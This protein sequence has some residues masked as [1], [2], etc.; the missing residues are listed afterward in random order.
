MLN[1][2]EIYRTAL[3][4]VNFKL[5]TDENLFYPPELDA[6]LDST[7][8]GLGALKIQPLRVDLPN[9]A[10]ASAVGSAPAVTDER[11]RSLAVELK[12][13]ERR[14]KSE[15]DH[16]M[17][18][19]TN[20]AEDAPMSD[21]SLLASDA[22]ADAQVPDEFSNLISEKQLFSDQVFF[23]NR[24]AR[25]DYLEFVIRAMGGEVVA[26]EPG[27]TTRREDPRITYEVVDRPSLERTFLGR[28]YVQPQY[29]FDCVNKNKLLPTTK[30][31]PGCALPPHL[32][33]FIDE[34]P[35][36]YVPRDAQADDVAG[37]VGSE[38][39]SQSSEFEEASASFETELQAEMAGVRAAAFAHSESRSLNK[40]KAQ[41]GDAL[42]QPQEE[43]ALGRV[44]MNAKQRRLAKKQDREQ[45]Q[46]REEAAR[47]EAKRAALARTKKRKIGS[48]D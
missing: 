44:L 41:R 6:A 20:G 16:D 4:F 24:E 48:K 26:E 5:Y 12:S 19:S 7:G 3:G 15:D 43:A 28:A 18:P 8:A 17:V 11:L 31:G 13:I 39:A 29:V 46:R 23:I 14:Q 27:S 42:E 9:E 38:E 10:I 32:S 2:L 21:A 1:F 33:P 25:H 34:R 37:D 45:R 47:L 30:Y 36:E 22:V 35:G 40:K